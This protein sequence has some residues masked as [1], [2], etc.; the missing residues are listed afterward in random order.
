MTLGPFKI[1]SFIYGIAFPALINRNSLGCAM[2]MGDL[3]Q[4]GTIQK[5]RVLS[6]YDGSRLDTFLAEQFL[7]YSRSFFAR[8]IGDEMVTVNGFVEKKSSRIVKEGDMVTVQF[9]KPRVVQAKDVD[10]NPPVELIYESPH[11][12]I[13]NKPAGL[14]MHAPSEMSDIITLVDW[15]LIHYQD[16]KGVGYVDRPGIVHRLDKDTSGLVIIPKTNY[17]HGV[18]GKLFHDRK[19]KKIYYAVVEGHPEK[20]GTIDLAIGRDPITKVKMST[21][22]GAAHQK[23]DALTH[24]EVIEYFDNAALVQVMP[25]TGRTHQIRVHFAA[26][27]HPLIG[28]ATYSKTSK[29]IARHAL[30]AQSLSFEFDGKLYTF[31]KEPPEDF[32]NLVARLRAGIKK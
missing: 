28:D 20:S 12:L 19:V 18:F 22:L 5:I 27:G 24:Y 16:L 29:Y 6:D 7:R 13:L 15:L 4:S 32:Q 14:V 8:L 3:I 11:F 23:R 21:K 1:L 10:I 9:H 2:S 25:A 17:A 26:I 30:H 31:E